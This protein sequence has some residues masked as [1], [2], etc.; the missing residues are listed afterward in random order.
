MKEGATA[1]K[2]RPPRWDSYPLPGRFAQAPSLRWNAGVRYWPGAVLLGSVVPLF[3]GLTIAFG[4]TDG[5]LIT[6][7]V[8]ATYPILLILAPMRKRLVPTEV[9]ASASSVPLRVWALGWL[10]LSAGTGL[11]PLVVN[12]NASD[13]QLLW[14]A[15]SLAWYG[16]AFG[17]AWLVGIAPAWEQWRHRPRRRSRRGRA[18][19]LD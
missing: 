2:Q 13:D 9:G 5:P 11:Y 6:A 17:G 4:F 7:A 1:E 14:S 12:W 19:T 15:V 10:L 18:G 3:V 8:V 16:L